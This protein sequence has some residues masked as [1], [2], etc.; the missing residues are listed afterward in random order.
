MICIEVEKQKVDIDKLLVRRF[1][2]V[3]CFLFSNS[4]LIWCPF[5]LLLLV[6]HVEFLLKWCFTCAGLSISVSAVY[7]LTKFA[8]KMCCLREGVV[9]KHLGSLLGFN[10]HFFCLF[11]L[12]SAESCLL[13][14]FLLS[15]TLTCAWTELRLVMSQHYSLSV[16]QFPLPFCD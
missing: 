7:V 16:L 4:A 8:V 12:F 6:L 5:T 11:V 15:Q 1:E 2:F 3:F 9:Q 10:Q 13:S 14:K